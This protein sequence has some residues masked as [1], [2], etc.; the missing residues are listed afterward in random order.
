MFIQLSSVQK[1]RAGPKVT[2]LLRPGVLYWGWNVIRHSHFFQQPSGIFGIPAAPS[3]SNCPGRWSSYLFVSIPP[4]LE[5]TQEPARL[6]NKTTGGWRW[7][8]NLFFF[9]TQWQ[10]KIYPFICLSLWG[11]MPKSKLEMKHQT[12]KHN[13]RA[14]CE[15]AT[16]CD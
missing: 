5:T 11:L 2:T 13:F 6:F 10:K 14:S 8:Y 7:D 4:P 3:P 12:W 1:R 9:C 15:A 16:C